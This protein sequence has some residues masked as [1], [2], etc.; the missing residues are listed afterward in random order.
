M[1][2]A[3]R[4]VEIRNFKWP[5]RPTAN[6]TGY[7]L[8]QDRFGLWLGIKAGSH[9]WA[10]DDSKRGIFASSFVKLIPE[11]TFWTVCFQLSDPIVDVDIVVPVCW[12][13]GAVEEI[14]LELDVVRS[15]DGTV[16]VRD[17][18]EFDRVRKQYSMPG[19]ISTR[20]E[21]TCEE[22][23]KLVE[24]ESEPFGSVGRGWLSR[25]LTICS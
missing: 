20:A 24:G 9:W 4:L 1:V 11:D 12:L 18:E 2:H 10:P 3:E 8:G 6:A 15:A 5:R 14:D 16:R 17:Q 23:R 7:L 22:I 19:D 13:D 25:F 21:A